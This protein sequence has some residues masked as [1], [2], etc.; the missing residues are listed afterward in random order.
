MS[1]ATEHLRRDARAWFGVLVIALMVFAALGAPAIAR[2]DPTA[3]DLING[4]QGP[5][6]TH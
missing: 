4:L 3:I 1:R 2:H 6:S 5:S